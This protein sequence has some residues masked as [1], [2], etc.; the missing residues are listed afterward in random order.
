MLRFLSLL[1]AASALFAADY[2]AGVARVNITPRENLWLSGYASR[3]RPAEGALN[4]LSAKAL[5]VEDK[6]GRR[7]VIVTTDLI[8]L[9]R[10]MTDAVSARL[11]KQHGLERSQILFNSSHTHTGPVIRA[12]LMTMYSLPPEQDRLLGDYSRQLTEDLFTVASAAL[13]QLKPASLRYAQGTAGFAINRREPSPTGVRIGLNPTGPTDRSVPVLQV[14]GEDGKPLAILFGYACHNT[15]LTGEHYKYSG[16]Y[17]GFAQSEIEAMYPGATALFLMLCGG[18]ANPNPRTR[19][20]HAR[21]HGKELA[22]S[23]KS[24]LDGATVPV[25][26]E[27]R[28]AFQTIRLN[29]RPH[30]REDFEKEAQSTNQYAARRAKEMLAAYDAGSPVR[31]TPYPVHALRFGKDMTILALGGEVVVD[32]ALRAKREFPKERLVVAGYSNDVMCY[33]PSLRVLKEGGYEAD[34]SMI[35][36]GMPGPFSEDVEDS[37]FSS[38]RAVLKRVGAK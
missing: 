13:G 27:L 4:E 2:R 14:T 37:I 28:S 10:V 11:Q 3:T 26:G 5:A 23:V 34:S 33:I 1:A 16:D 21:A 36:Y 29:F 38:I 12:N 8:G 19:E 6:K 9:P 35:Y 20:E 25:R 17:A 18:D 24:A 7:I 32:Y 22:A 31:N 15:T 30:T